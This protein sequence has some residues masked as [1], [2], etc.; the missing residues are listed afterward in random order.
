[1]VDFSK[2][3]KMGDVNVHDT[4][5]PKEKTD[6]NDE[7]FKTV[8]ISGSRQ[9][10]DEFTKNRLHIGMLQIKG[11]ENN[12]DTI[13]MM[14]YYRRQVLSNMVRVNKYDQP[15]CFSYADHDEEGNQ[16][17]TSGFFCPPNATSR[18]EVSWCNGCRTSFII[19]GFW[20][21]ES[22][23]YK[24]DADGK[25]INIYV[26]GTG[27]K[28]GDLMSYAF[29]C[30]DLEVPFLFDENSDESDT[31]EKRYSNL[32]RR[33][34]KI[35]AGEE[36]VYKTANTPANSPDT[37]ASYV[38]TGGKD[39]PKENVIKLMDYANNID[40]KLREKFDYTEA[41]KSK[42]KKYFKQQLN[43]F[44]NSQEFKS[45]NPNFVPE[46]LAG[47]A[48]PGFMT[49]DEPA[50]PVTQQYNEPQKVDTSNVPDSGSN[51][52]DDIPF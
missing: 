42:C 15:K 25:P 23:K 14:P 49:V 48:V 40:D 13:Y 50:E 29:D 27:S 4:Y 11:I 36:D 38:L 20:V 6:P 9:K 47:P 2:Y 30:Q 21:D 24:M 35:E 12:L 26:R 16:L 46:K 32:F 31:Y 43:A 22:G 45:V 18:G 17:S 33:I 52:I 5:T 19:A 7:F 3:A 39:I 37:R 28:V 41:T 51:P 34:I 1:M 10:E 8:Y 44:Q